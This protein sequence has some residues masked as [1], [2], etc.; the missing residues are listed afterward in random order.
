[1][2]T[3]GVGSTRD[4][5]LLHIKGTIAYL[6]SDTT[7]FVITKYTRGIDIPMSNGYIT[8]GS[9]R[10]VVPSR[11]GALVSVYYDHRYHVYAYS[12]YCGNGQG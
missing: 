9:L 3:T 6:H 7:M 11:I 12:F 1:M 2:G 5:L 10:A 4:E 8:C